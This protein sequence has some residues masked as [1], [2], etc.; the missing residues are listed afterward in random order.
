M[1]PLGKHSTFQVASVQQTYPQLTLNQ[2][3]RKEKKRKEKKRKEKKR[4]EKKIYAVKRHNGNLA[5]AQ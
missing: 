3:E 4:K 5:T 2:S 1:V